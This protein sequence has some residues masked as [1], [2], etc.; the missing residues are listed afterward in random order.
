MIYAGPQSRMA[1]EASVQFSANML[2]SLLEL[3][4]RH[5]APVWVGAEKVFKE[6]VPEGLKAAAAA[7]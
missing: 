5:T 3:P 7:V 6:K 2:R 4:N 1:V